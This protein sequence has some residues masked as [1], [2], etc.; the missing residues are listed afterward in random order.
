MFQPEQNI[1][2]H[3]WKKKKKKKE[4]RSR[5]GEKSTNSISSLWGV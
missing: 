5:A 1:E 3:K 4:L 2:T